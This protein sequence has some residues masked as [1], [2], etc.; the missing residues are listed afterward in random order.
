M[1]LFILFY[2]VFYFMLCC[3]PTSISCYYNFTWYLIL[4]LISCNV[5]LFH[6]I[7]LYFILL[8]ILL[9]VYSYIF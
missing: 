5:M 7:L 4:H 1:I 9:R 6:F 2:A 8:R 3:F